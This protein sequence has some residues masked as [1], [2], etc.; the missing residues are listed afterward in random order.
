MRSSLVLAALALT[1][2]VSLADMRETEACGA[3]IPRPGE[4]TIVTAHRMALSISP[5]QTVL[6]DQIQY[7]GTAE[8][9]AW[10]L[11]VKPGAYIELSSDAWFETLDAATSTQLFAPPV[12]CGGG[13]SGPSFGCGAMEERNF[14]AVDDSGGSTGSGGVGSSVTVVHRGS[15]GPFETVTLATDKPGVLNDW[16]TN[17]GYGLDPSTQP[18]IDAYVA[19]GF[20]FIALRLQPG[21]DVQAMKPVRVVQPGA[22]PTLPLRMV[23]IG[24][25]A[26]VSISLFVISEGRWEAKNFEN[27][28]APHD[29]LSWDF[30]SQSSNYKEM[31]EKLLAQNNGATWLTT[32][33][34]Q[35]ALLSPLDAAVFMG[36]PRLYNVGGTLSVDRISSAYVEQGALNGET[37][38]K[39]CVDAF[40]N[41]EHSSNIV[42]NPCPG[43]AP[44][45]DPS[46]GTVPSN[47][48]DARTLACD[49]LDD[50]AVSL[51]GLHPNDVW[52]TRLEANLPRAALASDLLIEASANQAPVDN[53]LQAASAT[54][55]EVVCGEP[56]AVAPLIGKDAGGRSSGRGS[57][58]VAF[59]MGLLALGALARR[60]PFLAKA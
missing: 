37:S 40:A 43:G 56:S 20:D 45:D 52:L 13:S 18:V 15:V 27:V 16:L 44:L 14:A 54:H 7:D 2:I 46:C 38:V 19:E 11:P 26:N 8:D 48:I 12:N 29:L 41:F 58:V 10:V 50:L 1:S 28:V 23:A 6:W 51:V 5:K 53:M 57:L 21:A 34:M 32:F 31:R 3:C 17:A 35:N 33:S 47:E 22:S 59:G 39:T 55:V 36:G 49:K 42:T 24:T 30:Q 9:F 60:R 4:N 25:G